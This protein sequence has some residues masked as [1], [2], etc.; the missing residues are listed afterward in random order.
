MYVQGVSTR[1]VTAVMEELC[2][3]EVSSAEVSRAAELLDQELEA[4][5]K[6]PIGCIKTLFFDARYEK[7]RHG[8]SVVSC[9]VLIASGITPEGRRTVLGVS[10]S[11]SEAE[12]HW[13]EF[14]ASLQDRG[15]HGVELIVSDDHAGL[16][17]ARIARFANVPWQRCQFHLQQNAQAYVPRQGLKKQVAAD[18]KGIFTAPDKTEALRLLDLAVKRY[19]TEAPK[20]AEWMEHNVPEGLTVLDRPVHQRPRLRTTNMME[21]TNK[22]ILRRTR[23]ATLFPNE[24]SLLRLVSAVLAEIDEEWTTGKVYLNLENP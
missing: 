18:L 23:V 20:L 22:E 12:V 5:R 11:L 13:R 3:L 4:W 14:M 6:R 10:V 19:A 8:G 2:G 1:K 16:K 15:L 9:A 24:A 7:V 21:R 17:A